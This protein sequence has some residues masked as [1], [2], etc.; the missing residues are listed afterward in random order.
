ME[1]KHLIDIAYE[2]AKE[3]YNDQSFTFNQL[4]DLVSKNDSADF[5]K[6]SIGE[7]YSELLLDPRFTY[8]GNENWKLREFLSENEL[9][10]INS[11]LY[12]IADEE[13]SKVS[14]TYVQEAQKDIDEDFQEDTS[15]S[16]E[17]ND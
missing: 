1:L 16:E 7:F 13:T 8:F 9:K 10:N 11:N 4:Y 14:E 5:P 12:D 3:T 17:L 15:A 2:Q 6:Q